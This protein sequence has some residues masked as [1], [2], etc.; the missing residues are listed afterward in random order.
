MKFNDILEILVEKK[1]SNKPKKFDQAR[2]I[3]YIEKT[4]SILEDIHG[5]FMEN[6]VYK[7][8]PI[9]LTSAIS[10]LKR[11]AQMYKV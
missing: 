10:A 1:K 2:A 8:P 9:E 7:T 5:D 11:F 4:A 3:S 6:D